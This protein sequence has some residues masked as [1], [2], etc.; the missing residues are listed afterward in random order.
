MGGKLVGWLVAVT[1]VCTSS[2]LVEAGPSGG[3]LPPQ[4]VQVLQVAGNHGV[5]ND[6]EMVAVNITAVAPAEAGHI[7]AYPCDQDLPT[8]SNLNYGPDDVVPNLAL[9]RIA[10]DGS[11]CIATHAVV[12]LVVDVVG[13]V[14]AGSTIT[15]LDTP[16]RVTDTRASRRLAGGD[17]LQIELDRFVP[18]DTRLAMFNLTSVGATA[19]GHTTVFPCT[20]DVP[21][22]SSLNFEPGRTVANFVIARLSPDGRVCLH[23]HAA[24]H[25]VVDLV[26]YSSGGMTTLDRPRRIHDS[27]ATGRPVSGGDTLRLDVTDLRSI[28]DSATAAVYNLT[29]AAP[30]APGHATSYPCDTRRLEASNLNYRP[31]RNSANATITKLSATGELCIHTLATTHLVVDLIGYT[32]DT[33]DYVPLTPERI[34]DT[35]RGWRPTCDLAIVES[36]IRGDRLVDRSGETVSE[37]ALT[38]LPDDAQLEIHPDCESLIVLDAEAVHRFEWSTNRM[39]TISTEH[40]SHVNVLG[41]GT[42]VGYRSEFE[43]G[44]PTGRQIGENIETGEPMVTFV[45]GD[46]SFDERWAV[47]GSHGAPTLSDDRA[48]FAYRGEVTH[49]STGDVVQFGQGQLSPNG[50]LVLGKARRAT[51]GPEP[52]GPPVGT[53]SIHVQCDV[54]TSWGDHVTTIDVEIPSQYAWWF[55]IC[56]WASDGRVIVGGDGSW[57]SV[58]LYGPQRSVFETLDRADSWLLHH[59][60]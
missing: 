40:H 7:T 59:Y 14:P 46:E 41:D 53:T 56:A 35:R 10:D 45:P 17:R 6:A 49:L 47:P 33:N 1:L 42:I 57:Y 52:D 39:T 34:E 43:D 54:S 58:D 37:L 26:A 21:A 15:A 24:S 16:R 28:P 50:A 5:P 32:T 13:Y 11:I 55:E 12:D 31:G 36:A 25:F 9:V 3:A 27:R 60:R 2:G 38:S 4:L 51:I 48:V 22:T 44:W 18:D 30:A 23:T 29:A 20:D 19:P 8:V